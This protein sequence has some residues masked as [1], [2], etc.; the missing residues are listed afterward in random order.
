MPFYSMSVSSKMHLCLAH[1][2]NDLWGVGVFALHALSMWQ[3]GHVVCILQLHPP[4]C[5]AICTYTIASMRWALSCA[6]TKHRPCLLLC[7]Y[8]VQEIHKKK[9]ENPQLVD[10]AQT[11][12]VASSMQK[13]SGQQSN[14]RW[15]F[16]QDVVAAFSCTLCHHVLLA[17][18]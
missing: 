11:S 1:V 12:G 8:K 9:I 2:L 4:N 14:V 17:Y 13:E 10:P 3:P 16:I 15:A 6:A 7:S 5:Q 18:P